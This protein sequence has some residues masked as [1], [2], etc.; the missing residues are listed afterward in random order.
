MRRAGRWALLILWLCFSIE[1]VISPTSLGWLS[2]LYP[3]FFGVAIAFQVYRFRRVS[4]PVERQQ[5]KWAVFG[6]T[7]SLLANQLFWLPSGLTA[8][9]ETLY[10]PISF[11]V[12]LLA[13]LLVPITFF[14]AIQRYQLY[15][16]D[17]IINKA[18]V[19]GLLTGILGAIFVGGVITLQALVRI[20]TGQDSPVALVAST[21]LIAGLF[22]PLRSRIQKTIEPPLLPRQVRRAEDSCRLQRYIAAGS[23]SQRT[24]GATSR[25]CENR[26]CG[27]CAYPYGS[28]RARPSIGHVNCHRKPWRAIAVSWYCPASSAASPL[29]CL[30]KNL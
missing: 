23:Q 11:L 5:T 29:S 17:R 1:Q 24:T 12:Y 7:I 2:L 8:L 25:R 14:I 6:L 30:L 4:T 27:R 19:Y 10:M 28:R 22:Q 20:V 16:I 3:L 15:E 26:R 21:L 9:G 13:C 18:L